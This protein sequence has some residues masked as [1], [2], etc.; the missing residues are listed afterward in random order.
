M[1]KGNPFSYLNI[2]RR[3]GLDRSMWEDQGLPIGQ[4]R[5]KV[6]RQT[7]TGARV[8]KKERGDKR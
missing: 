3:K 2:E 5:I 6:W 1:G 8:Q 7:V 4:E